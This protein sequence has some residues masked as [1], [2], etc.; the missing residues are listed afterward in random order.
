MPYTE[1]YFFSANQIVSSSAHRP[2]AKALFKSINEDQT[3]LLALTTGVTTTWTTHTNK[4]LITG[5]PDAQTDGR[6]E[7][8]TASMETF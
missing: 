5:Q 8:L 7:D 2:S 6:V 1:A 4:D 3:K